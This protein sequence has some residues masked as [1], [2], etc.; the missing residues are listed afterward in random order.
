MEIKSLT[1]VG[2]SNNPKK[3]GYRALKKALEEEIEVYAVN[4]N[5]RDIQ[6]DLSGGERRNVSVFETVGEVPR[7]TEYVALYIPRRAI[8]KSKILEQ[9]ADKGFSN[10]IIPPDESFSEKSIELGGEIR[11]RLKGRGY[12]DDQILIDACYL[13]GI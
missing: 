7:A 2:A 8:L 9:I 6:I 1:I 5:K 4:T 10:V 13:R 12:N 3:F 11:S